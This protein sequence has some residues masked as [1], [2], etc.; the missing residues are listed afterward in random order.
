MK[1]TTQK[2][3]DLLNALIAEK[4][5]H[6]DVIMRELNDMQAKLHACT[7][8]EEISAVEADLR[9]SLKIADEEI[10]FIRKAKRTIAKFY[11]PAT[12]A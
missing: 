9:D 11:E 7:T 8:L 6:L 1:H 5:A 12:A 10:K 2:D 4:R 3:V